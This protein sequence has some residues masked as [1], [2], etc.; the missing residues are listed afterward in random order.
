MKNLLQ[1]LTALLIASVLTACGGGEK[2]N[3]ATNMDSFTSA[4]LIIDNGRGTFNGRDTE[5]PP[6]P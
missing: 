6:K 4:E 3:A 1:I 5:V 2:S